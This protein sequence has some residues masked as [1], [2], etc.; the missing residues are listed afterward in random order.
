VP[1]REAWLERFAGPAGEEKL[2]E[3]LCRSLKTA[4]KVA[5]LPS[6]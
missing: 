5:A 3:H 1:R 6:R 4:D 2:F